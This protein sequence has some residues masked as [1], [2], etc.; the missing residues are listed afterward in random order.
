LGFL[1]CIPNTS[2]LF[3]DRLDPNL[4]IRIAGIVDWLA[5]Q[6]ALQLPQYFSGAMVNASLG[7]LI[8]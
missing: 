1:V 2:T 8:Q 5:A 7:D 3:R 6:G 4:V